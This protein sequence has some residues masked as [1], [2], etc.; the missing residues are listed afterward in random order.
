MDWFHR[1]LLMAEGLEMQSQNGGAGL[2]LARREW[3]WKR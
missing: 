1:F 3:F 2:A